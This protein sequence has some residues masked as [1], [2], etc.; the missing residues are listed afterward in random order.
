[1]QDEQLSIF[2]TA[3]IALTHTVNGLNEVQRLIIPLVGESKLG[4]KFN[5]AQDR[6]ARR[7]T[8]V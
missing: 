8:E 3:I 1:M 6:W 4:E 7:E 2:A 5:R